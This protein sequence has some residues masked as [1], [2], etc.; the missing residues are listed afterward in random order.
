MESEQGVT[1][2]KS[3][4]I[5]AFI[6]NISIMIHFI[7]TQFTT[8]E[9]LNTIYDSLTFWFDISKFM[10]SVQIPNEEAYLREL[11]PFEKNVASFYE[12]G[13]NKML[14]KN[15]DGNDELFY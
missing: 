7:K 14:N 15:L 12:C 11:S 2:F 4:D 10:H 8:S 13:R 6:T 5:L 3:V 1:S 9:F